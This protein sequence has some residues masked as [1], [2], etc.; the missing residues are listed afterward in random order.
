MSEDK[1]S[2][3]AV[4][5]GNIFRCVVAANHLDAAI[6][7]VVAHYDD[8][9]E[10]ELNPGKIFSVVKVGDSGGNETYFATE[11]VMQKAGFEIKEDEA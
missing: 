10:D 5:S 11:A 7:A 1:K 4:S 6:S 3:Y 2:A 8:S 9:D